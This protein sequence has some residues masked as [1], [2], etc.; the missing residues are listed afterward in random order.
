MQL[1][2]VKNYEELSREAARFL[3]RRLLAKPDLVL[4][5][6]TGDTLIG[7][8]RELVRLHREGLLDLSRATAFNLDEYL[9]IPPDHPQSFKS[10]MH[11]H[12]WDHVN[13]RRENAHI[14]NSLPKDPEAEC[15]RYE[16]LIEKAGGI[17]LAV[18]G[19]GENGHIAFNEP[20]TPF[21]SLTHVAEL[22]EETREREAQAF[23]GLEHVPRQAI[24]MGIRTI[25]LSREVL[26]LV[27]GEGKREIL[28]RALTGPI[29]PE[30]PGSALQ[31]HPAL[32]VICDRAAA[33]LL[34]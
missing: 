22:S 8:Y 20:G 24:T 15:H 32:T 12:L 34:E 21:G 19:L 14:P 25:M 3:A 6:P 28:F 30:V 26:L 23:G 5:L 13:L 7:M 31:L 33:S 10:Y 27:S 29:T 1:V 17:D 18:L 11:R 9:G 4:A 2:V 16:G